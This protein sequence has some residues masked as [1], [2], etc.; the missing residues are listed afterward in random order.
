M[1]VRVLLRQVKIRVSLG[2]ARLSHWPQF[3][4]AV[5]RCKAD[6]DGRPPTTQVKREKGKS[7]LSSVSASSNSAFRSLSSS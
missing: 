6:G 7:I 3:A 5:I 1:S 4:T 2:A